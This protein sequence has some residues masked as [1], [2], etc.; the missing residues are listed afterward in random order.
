MVAIDFMVLSDWLFGG[1]HAFS[2]GKGVSGSFGFVQGA[3]K[4]E[5]QEAIHEQG[6]GQ[7]WG[8]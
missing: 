2:G 1:C 3:I 8:E 5:G 7:Y 4:V 6:G